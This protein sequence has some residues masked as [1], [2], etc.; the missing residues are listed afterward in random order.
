MPNYPQTVS[1]VIRD[2]HRYKP[3]VLA[4]LRAFRRARPWRGTVPERA[5]KLRTLHDAL[6]RIYGRE[7]TLTLA[8]GDTEAPRGNGWCSG[9]RRHIG[10]VGRLS[11]VTFLHEWA[12]VLFGP[13]ERKACE[14]SVNLYRRMFPRSA[15]RM[16]SPVLS[17]SNMI[18]RTSGHLIVHPATQARA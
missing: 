16:L 12:H 17:S 7:V 6:C 14:W 8:V 1:E 9:D 2:G 3:E 10:L 4:A 13:C 5:E 18:Y 15:A 11:V